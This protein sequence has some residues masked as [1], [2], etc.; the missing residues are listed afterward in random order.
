MTLLQHLAPIMRPESA[1][2]FQAGTHGKIDATMAVGQYIQFGNLAFIKLETW[3]HASD[4]VTSGTIVPTSSINLFIGFVATS[5][6]ESVRSNPGTITHNDDNLRNASNGYAE[7]I[8][9][10]IN[11][12]V[13]QTTN[14]DLMSS[15]NIDI[16]GVYMA[17][18]TAPPHDSL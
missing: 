12:L 6:E 18:G 4:N 13:E 9:P 14:D 15:S 17:D 5:D 7:S 3:R 8:Y 10:I 1:A 11:N 2:E 16:G